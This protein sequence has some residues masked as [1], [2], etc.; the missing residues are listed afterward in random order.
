MAGKRNS[1]ARCLLKRSSEF[2]H[3]FFSYL[4]FVVVGAVT[5]A[6]SRMLFATHVNAKV[7]CAVVRFVAVHVVDALFGCKRPSKVC[8]HDEPVFHNRLPAT[9]H[10]AEV[11][12]KFI[13][14][15]ANV[16]ENISSVGKF[17]VGAVSA[18]NPLVVSGL[19]L[20]PSAFFAKPLKILALHFNT[21]F[22]CWPLPRNS[23]TRA[24]HIDKHF[25]SS[26]QTA[27]A[28]FFPNSRMFN[29]RVIRNSSHVYLP[30]F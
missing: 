7:L 8:S 4:P 27:N 18:M 13:G 22:A 16:N 10:G 23:A 24:R 11:F 9:L 25:A 19:Q 29:R 2:A 30:F 21:H 1:T 5:W 12:N 3:A 14:N 26:V 15:G 20:R 6:T 17:F 28:H